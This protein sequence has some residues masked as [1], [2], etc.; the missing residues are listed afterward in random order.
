[1]M[2]MCDG[3]FLTSIQ[4]K[5]PLERTYEPFAKREI[6]PVISVSTHTEMAAGQEHI[7]HNT[8]IPA[9]PTPMTRKQK[10]C[11]TGQIWS[12]ALSLR[13]FGC[14]CMNFFSLYAENIVSNVHL[15]W[16]TVWLGCWK[17]F[18]N[19]YHFWWAETRFVT[20][21]HYFFLSVGCW[22]VWICVFSVFVNRCYIGCEWWKLFAL[23]P[24]TVCVCLRVWTLRRQPWIVRCWWATRILGWAL[25]HRLAT[26]EQV[27]KEYACV[28]VCV[29]SKQYRM[30]F[31]R[32]MTAY[33]QQWT[34]IFLSLM[35]RDVDRFFIISCVWHPLNYWY[36]KNWC[37]TQSDSFGAR[38]R[39]RPAQ[40]P[41]RRRVFYRV[42]YF[43]NDGTSDGNDARKKPTTP[44]NRIRTT[45]VICRTQLV[46]PRIRCKNA[47]TL[48]QW[49]VLRARILTEFFA[50]HLKIH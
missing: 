2:I 28:C 18:C 48:F 6:L 36:Y 11:G 5:L 39:Q 8:R 34:R 43:S 26:S 35:N 23:V 10:W 42:R 30:Q 27:V 29:H 20:R 14:L 9:P 22:C 44:A 1:M 4:V 46:A 16:R 40:Y 24:A 32:P 31:A 37:H 47:S 13:T 25:I 41:Q 45:V 38:D 19:N 15:S 7:Q 50:S 33:K 49:N 12:I 17:W 21:F 3:V